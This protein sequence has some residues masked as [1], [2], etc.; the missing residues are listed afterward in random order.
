MASSCF[1][2]QIKYMVKQERVHEVLLLLYY[3]YYII[4]IMIII[5][6]VLVTPACRM[7]VYVIIF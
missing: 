1:V 6:L 3:Y 4:I 7:T 2:A 5:L